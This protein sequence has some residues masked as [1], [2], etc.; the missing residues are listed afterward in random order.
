MVKSGKLRSGAA[1][2]VRRWK[3]GHSSDSNPETNRYR[4]AARSRYFS[5]PSEKSDL[6]V[7]ALKLHNDLQSGS[8]QQSSDVA[9][10]SMEDEALTEKTSG[11]FLSGL[12]DC[13]NL[14]FRKVQRY[15]ESNSATHKEI[16]AVLAAVT[17][18]IR[19][20]GGKET[21]TEYFAALMTTLEAVDSSESLAAVAYLLNLVMK[22]MPPAVLKKK[23]SDTAKAFMDAI[24]NQSNSYSILYLR[25]ILS[26]LATLLRKQDLSV[27][28]YPS[29]LQVYHGLLS[30]TV[31]SKPKVRKAAQQGI[32]SVLRYSD[33]MFSDN[34]PNHHPAA[35][36]TA[37]F[38]CKELEQSG[39]SKEDTTTLHILGLL[40][41]LLSAFP[42]S[43]VKSCCET[44]LRV[45]TL[46]HVLVTAH[47]MQ[48]FHKLFIS[49]PST[50]SMS[51]E[52]NAQII[53]ALYD[54]VPSENDLQPLLAWLAVMEKAHVHLSSLQSSLC[55]GHLPRLFSVTMSCLLSP[56]T[57]VVSAAASTMK[58]LIND[59]VASHM[60][61]IGPVQPNTSSG[62]GACVLKM[63]H[64]VEEGL[65]YRFHASWPFVLKILGCFYRAAGKQAHP[66]MIKSLQSLSDLRA[67]PQF[68]F[69]GELDLAVGG[70]VESMGPEVVL[71]AVPLLITGTDDDLEFPR[72]WL[73]PVIRDH[74]KN[75]QLAYFNSHFFPLAN[76]LKQTADELEQS[77]QKLMAKVY[78]TLQMQ[79]WTMLPGFCTKPTDLLVSFKGIARSLGM[80]L[81]DRP[82]LRMCICQ[83]LRTLINKS[84]ETEEEKAEM[85][86]FSKNFLPILFN[87]YSQQPKPGEMTS[88]RMAVLDTIR[89]YLTITDQTMVCTFLQKALERLNADNTEFTR[90]AVIDLVVAMAPFVD[91]ASMSQI[92]EFIKPFVESKDTGIQKKAYR[93]LEEICGGERASCK[94]FV[95][96]NLEQLKKMLMESLKTAASP[97]K[98]PRLKCLIHI[99][100]QLNE[101]HRDFITALLPEVILC[102]KE[103]SIGAR[104]NAYTLL[105][106]IG[107]A[108]ERFCGNTKDAI[109]EYLGYVYIGL[110]GSVTLITCTV[111]AL[112]RLIFHYK[113]SIDLSSLELLL[114]NVCLLL[115][116]RTRDIVKASLGFL[117]VIIFS[118]DVKVLAG[119]VNVIMEGISNMNDMRRHFRVKLKN[120]Y[121]KL[122]RKFGFE[123]V[124][125]M[126]PAEQHK[127]L[128]NIRK[129]EARNKKRKLTKTEEDESDTEDGKPKVKGESI[130]DILAETDSDDSD[131][132]EKRKKGQKK[133][134]KKKGQ[135]WLKEGVSDEPLNFLDP[136]AAQRVLATNPNLKKATK[137][138]HGFKV[139]S[140]GRLIIKEEDDDDY[141]EEKTKDAEMDDVL[142]EAGVKTKKNPKRK[143]AADL[144]DDMDVEPALKYKAGGIGIHRPLGGR[145]EIGTEYKSK[146]GKGDIKKAGKCDP[147]AY[148][149]LKKSQLNRRKKAKLQGQ[150][151]G[152]VRGAKKGALS[153]SRILKKRKA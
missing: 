109:N 148:I 97:A 113:D 59:C 78:Q 33:F 100:K 83:A 91:E 32:C 46:S 12:S 40:K 48:A 57:Q 94:A 116:S 54:Y 44:L 138:D 145:P 123:L 128:G 14:T 41:D 1:Q 76:K 142:E 67:T 13:S 141:E 111:L 125:S 96:A 153:G 104:K 112:T 42:L 152:M 117:K 28:S 22:R 140:D 81:N 37:K 135:A 137:A 51:A 146:K 20:Q 16:C 53:T 49:K 98:R 61:E 107:N 85:N 62:N 144:D 95:L 108:F 102:T 15:W 36:S 139:T 90:L 82:D 121:T 64:I 8:L 4:K 119:H 133:P 84:C 43:S 11:T 130:E 87:V 30:F 69:T 58:T 143:I 150:F 21:E 136:K 63:F 66:I 56:H 118:L 26:C 106:E 68:P 74:V 126:L 120:I 47:A 9:G 52:L 134:M 24:S 23:F 65:S 99:V 72:S 39:G 2:K 5:R 6:T 132:D 10:D 35:V 105:V 18:V 129:S 7:D 92:L 50:S 122:I 124:K 70:A 75:S 149:P 147:Y 29:T 103:M 110:T 45:M 131:E 60:A 31:H 101:E 151:K 71:N 55:L 73:I 77:G 25:W 89:V 127:V 86:R 88:A 3:K 34:A 114:Q 93:V 27:W 17:E 38:C 115:T 19:S 80:A 79:I